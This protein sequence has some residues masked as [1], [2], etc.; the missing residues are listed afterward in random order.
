MKKRTFIFLPFVFGKKFG[1]AKKSP[2]TLPGF[3]PVF[4]PEQGEQGGLVN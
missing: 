3:D 1:L 4:G 2:L